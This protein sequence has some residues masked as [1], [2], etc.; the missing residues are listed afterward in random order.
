[1][2]CRFFAIVFLWRCEIH[3]TSLFG[4]LWIDRRCD[5][6]AEQGRQLH[7]RSSDPQQPELRGSSVGPLETHH[8]ESGVVDSHAD[9]ARR[10]EC[11]GAHGQLDQRARPVHPAQRNQPV[12]SGELASL[13]RRHCAPRGCACR[14][15]PPRRS[16]V[17]RTHHRW[18]GGERR[19]HEHLRDDHS[20]V[21]RVHLP[22]DQPREKPDL[23]ADAVRWDWYR[24]SRRR[25][26]DVGTGSVRIHR[27]RSNPRHPDGRGRCDSPPLPFRH[28]GFDGRIDVR[29]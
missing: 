5:L 16:A 24:S 13:A 29:I 21:A 4:G 20:Q 8:L 14:R 28:S 6:L 23:P 27:D 17:Q 18:D 19:H 3:L 15:H 11:A 2:C 1:M 9:S 12:Q 10:L 25:P 7:A 22:T 26:R